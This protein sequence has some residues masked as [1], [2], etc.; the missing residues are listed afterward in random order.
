MQI[1]YAMLHRYK[2]MKCYLFGKALP[3]QNSV[4]Y[5]LT[6][7]RHISFRLKLTAIKAD[8]F[9]LLENGTVCLYRGVVI[10]LIRLLLNIL[11]D[12]H[13]YKIKCI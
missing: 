7:S 1:L 11:I 12:L 4:Q 9:Y 13:R 6:V 5:T 2:I 3:L 8:M 10:I